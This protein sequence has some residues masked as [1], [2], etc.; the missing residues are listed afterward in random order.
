[1]WRV[2]IR[3]EGER[4]HKLIFW[5]KGACTRR[6]AQHDTFSRDTLTFSTTKARM[7][8]KSMEPPSGG[9]RPRNRFRYGSQTV[10]CTEHYQYYRKIMAWYFEPTPFMR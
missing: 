4:G 6:R 8:E 2:G 10:L 3:V 5:T 7:G 9:S 1:M